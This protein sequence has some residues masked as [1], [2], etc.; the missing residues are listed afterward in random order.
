MKLS[1]FLFLYISFWLP[2][3][4]CAQMLQIDSENQK[5]TAQLGTNYMAFLGVNNENG[6]WVGLGT[7]TAGLQATC[8]QTNAARFL[9]SVIF[10]NYGDGAVLL[11]LKSE[12]PWEFRQKNTGAATALEL[13]SVGGGGN[14]NFLITTNGRVGIDVINPT[15]KLHVNGEVMASDYSRSS[16]IRWKKNVRP[17]QDALTKITQLRG[18]TYQWKDSGRADLGFIAEEVAPILP[19]LVRMETN[20]ID[21][22]S[23][24]YAAIIPVLVEAVKE[25]QQKINRLAK[26][27]ESSNHQ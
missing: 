9:G 20:G 4:S 12:R 17:L 3:S 24:D 1:T 27:I 25:L 2:A 16:S 10:Q 13:A 6:C 15:S 14:K 21:A 18:V 23:V 7:P 26:Q 8:F 5:Y 19:E 11:E 22:R